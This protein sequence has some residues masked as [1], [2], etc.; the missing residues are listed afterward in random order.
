MQLT[1]DT[2]ALLQS[3]FLLSQLLAPRDLLNQLLGHPVELL[4]QLPD[5]ILLL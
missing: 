2:R 1:R 4:L 5:F 3:S